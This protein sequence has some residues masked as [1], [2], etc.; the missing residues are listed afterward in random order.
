MKLTRDILG[1]PRRRWLI[2]FVW[3]GGALAMWQAI[4]QLLWLADGNVASPMM[5]A[6]RGPE[7]MADALYLDVRYLHRAGPVMVWLVAVWAAG[8]LGARIGGRRVAAASAMLLAGGPHVVAMVHQEAYL[9]AALMVPAAVMVAV[10]M[11]RAM[12]RV[13]RYGGPAYVL[14]ML[15]AMAGQVMPDAKKSGY[16]LEVAPWQQMALVAMRELPKDELIAAWPGEGRV[17]EWVPYL[18]QRR[19]LV[20]AR[21]LEG[22]DGQRAMLAVAEATLAVSSEAMWRLRDDLH[23]RYLLV[24]EPDLTGHQPPAVPEALKAQ[25]NLLWRAGGR[26]FIVPQL[27]KR[28]AVYQG[29]GVVIL[30]LKLI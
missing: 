13:K 19:A 7:T 27:L 29:E 20:L 28:A 16:T 4:V 23:V 24:Q 6:W 17:I 8:K 2:L 22:P 12:G 10:V 26:G 14:A 18:A 15:A 9:M 11:K 3:G 1:S 5:L 25:V 30:D 21:D